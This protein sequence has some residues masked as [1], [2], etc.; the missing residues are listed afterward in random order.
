MRIEFERSGGLAGMRIAVSIDTDTLAES[1][2]EEL[3]ELVDDSNFFELPEETGTSAGAD[4]FTYKLTV[5]SEGRQ[6]T[7]TT[8]DTEAPPAL[9]ALLERLERQARRARGQ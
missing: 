3:T 1:E 9:S 7:V 4:V 6:H 2:A 8:S 5:E